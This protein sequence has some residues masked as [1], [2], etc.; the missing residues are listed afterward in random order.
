MNEIVA[1]E[2]RIISFDIAFPMIRKLELPLD[3]Q[4]SCIAFFLNLPEEYL[5]I[6][7]L[8]RGGNVCALELWEIHCHANACA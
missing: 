1:A 7:T 2:V 3:K 4:I 8:F 6:V 5:E